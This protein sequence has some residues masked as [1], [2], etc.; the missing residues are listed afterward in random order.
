MLM[1]V[2]VSIPLIAIIIIVT[3]ILIPVWRDRPVFPWFR[4]ERKLKSAMVELEQQHVE[5][6]L[7]EQV[8]IS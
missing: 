4:T 3:Q 6:Q 1:L 5:Q 8:Q 7:A 2:E